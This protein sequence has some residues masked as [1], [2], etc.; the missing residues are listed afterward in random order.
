MLYLT[1]KAGDSIRFTL[2]SGDIIW[3]AF[4]SVDRNK[5]HIGIQA[6]RSIAIDRHKLVAVTER[7]IQE[8]PPE[9]P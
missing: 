5:I 4:N 2:P 1:Q 3:I 9:K 7:L 6:P 8:V